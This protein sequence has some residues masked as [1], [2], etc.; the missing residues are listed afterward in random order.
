MNDTVI[1]FDLG[2]RKWSAGKA[3]E[4][5]GKVK[6]SD[7]YTVIAPEGMN[8]ADQLWILM[9]SARSHILLNA[10]DIVVVEEPLQ[11]NNRKYSLQIAEVK[12]AVLAGVASAIEK[13][14][15]NVYVTGAN[16]K[17]WKKD[18]LGNGNATKTDIATFLT[19]HYRVYSAVCGN[20]DELDAG[21]V[22]IYGARIQSRARLLSEQ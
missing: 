1:G 18:V 12:G 5:N 7:P 3:T 9:A 22:A 4:S 2:T 15:H 6:L 8:R 19:E 10:P 16:V 14:P 21:C 20:Q 11:G 13:I 17:T